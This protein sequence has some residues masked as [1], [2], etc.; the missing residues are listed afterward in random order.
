[1]YKIAR[2]QHIIK[3]RGNIHR[4]ELIDL[5]K[6]SINDYN[7]LKSYMEHKFANT[8]KYTKETQEWTWL[9]PEQKQETVVPNE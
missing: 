4:W 2:M 7:K 5:A 3:L 9:Y 1:M 6:I 8:V